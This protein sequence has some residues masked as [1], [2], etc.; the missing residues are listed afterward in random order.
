MLVPIRKLTKKSRN[1]F[2]KPLFTEFVCWNLFK[3]IATK[4]IIISDK[5]SST[6]IAL[7]IHRV[8]QYLYREHIRKINSC[9]NVSVTE[10]LVGNIYVQWDV[11]RQLYIKKRT[12]FSF[13]KLSRYPHVESKSQKYWLDFYKWVGQHELFL[14]INYRLSKRESLSITTRIYII[15]LVSNIIE[16][17]IVH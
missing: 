10:V 3:L 17:E 6:F 8:F 7:F 1:A 4:T 13:S 14:T 9:E 16:I 11:F 2:T 5:D 12:I 15:C